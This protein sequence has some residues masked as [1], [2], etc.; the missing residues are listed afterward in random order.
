[1]KND[2]T[3]EFIADYCKQLSSLAEDVGKDTLAHLLKVAELEARKERRS[4]A[5][6]S[7]SRV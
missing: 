6:R 1:M 2:Q 3:V 4:E 7:K 5:K